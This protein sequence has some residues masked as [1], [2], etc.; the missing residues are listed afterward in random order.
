MKV[1]VTL[2]DK[3]HP[4]LPIFIHQFNRH[5]SSDQEVVVVGFSPPACYLPPNFSFYSIGPQEHYPFQQWSNALMRFLTHL[6]DEDADPIFCLM[7]EDYILTR[8]VNTEAVKILYDYMHQFKYVIKADLC[9][10]RLYSHMADVRYGTAGYLDLV[11][12]DPDSPYHMSLWPGLWNRTH[13]MNILQFDWSPHDVEIHGTPELARN[14][15]IIVIGTR[16]A[17]LRITNIIRGDPENPDLSGLSEADR[18][19]LREAGCI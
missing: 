6:N 17:P 9:E 5:W 11:K 15:D 13:L 16:Q 10:D 19:S 3:Y 1:Y 14:P 4:I 2:A 7:L 12:S 8:K 18:Q